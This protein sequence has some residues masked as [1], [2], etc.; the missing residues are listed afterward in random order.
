MTVDVVIYVLLQSCLKFILA[1]VFLAVLHVAGGQEFPL[2]RLPYLLLGVFFE[3]L[4]V[5]RKFEHSV[6]SC[7]NQRRRPTCCRS[8]SGIPRHSPGQRDARS[9]C[10]LRIPLEARHRV[11][12]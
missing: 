10:R 6:I 9:L 7:D 11:P 8:F 5:D 12:S 3:V 2:E 4:K 1:L